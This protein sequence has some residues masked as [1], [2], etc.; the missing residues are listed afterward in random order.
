[1]TTLT[2]PFEIA[3]E[4]LRLLAGRRIPPTPD[5]YLTLYH[6][7]AGTKPSGNAFPE[8]QLR[9]LAAALPKASPDQ[10]RLARQLDDAVK[11]ANWDEYK[12]HLV[13]FINNLAE[14]QKLAWAELI[15]DLLRQ[16]DAKHP[17]LT[18]ARK[19]ESLEHV[20][21]GS[22]ANPELLFTRL[23]NLLRAWG[24]G[25]ESDSSPPPA[26]EP[27]APTAPEIGTN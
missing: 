12:G 4:T 3:R 10:M 9:S 25:K 5:N 22:S 21:S 11:A 24:Q 17:G 19:R 1:M 8:A 27:L 14:S 7:I 18:A 13:G 2:N 20:L 15:A 16:W 26:T 6:E 23:Q